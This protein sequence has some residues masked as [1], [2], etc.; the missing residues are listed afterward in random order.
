MNKTSQKGFMALIITQ[1]L[2]AFNDNAFKF[3]VA[4]FIVDLMGKQ[5]GTIYLALSGA[6][7][8]LPF[9]L[10]STMGGFLADRF[11][12]RRVIIATKMLEVVVMVLG[13]IALAC[14]IIW[15]MLAVLFLMGLQSALFGPSKY[16]ILPEI[17]PS[18]K[19][20]ESNGIL[21]MWTY[22]AILL[23]Q[24]SYGFMIHQVGPHI[25]YTAFYFMAIALLGLAVSVF[26][27]KVPPSGS[28]RDYQA[29]ILKEFAQNIIR[30]KKQDQSIFMSMLG[31]AYF[32]FLG[33]LFQPNVLL[34]ARKILMIDHLQTGLIVG[35]MTVGLGLGCFLAGK[36]SD[37]KIELGLVPLGSIGLSLFSLI[38][39]TF[40]RYDPMILLMMFCLGMSCGFFIVPLNTLIQQQSPAQERGQ[41]LATNN[42]LSF[43]AIL[44]GSIALFV[45]RD[46]VRLNAAQIFIATGIATMAG[47]FYITR[48][49]PYAF[50]RFLIWTLTHTLYRIKVIDRDNLPQQG[51]ALLTPN[52][53]SYL[54]AVILVVTS[55]RPI[56]FMV[57]R[58]IYNIWWLK[59]IL[60]T[61]Q[62]IPVDGKD[63]PKEIIRSLRLAKDRLSAGELVCVFPEGQLS[64][65]GNM[66]KFRQGIEV[67][68]KGV[69][70]PIIPVHID[71]I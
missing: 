12:K 69:E 7:F 35:A 49:V 11:S 33:G 56:R 32:G 18:D 71:R 17:V 25:H 40:Q 65:T 68:M 6:V 53:M 37:Q 67:I 26:I 5:G 59:P 28:Q 3:V 31:L 10:A 13:F 27:T 52:H 4:A 51:G 15:P 66:L 62:A 14:D 57:H 58:E 8:I 34:Y 24:M 22:I 70:V 44:A 63:K 36:L 29:N 2:G 9:I 45:L 16:G 42:M 1:F 54:D 20:S 41:I 39:G 21:Q 43:S 23:G 30:I 19:L 60:K 50:I 55:Q 64:R 48:Q 38:L 47:T 46:W 61:A